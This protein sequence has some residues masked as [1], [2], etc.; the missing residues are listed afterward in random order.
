VGFL[1]VIELIL[2]EFYSPVNPG[3]FSNAEVFYA[4]GETM[5]RLAAPAKALP[6]LEKAYV[7]DSFV[8]PAWAF[9]KSHSYALMKQWGEAL[10]R[11]LPVLERVPAFVPGRVQT[12]R[13]LQEMGRTKD[14]AIAIRLLREFAPRYSLLNAARMFPYPV[15]AERKRLLSALRAAALPEAPATPKPSS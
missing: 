6:L 2:G 10:A 1:S 3:R 13:V 12:A 7:L 4:Y 14:A 8:P 5:N 9:A 15:A 11:M